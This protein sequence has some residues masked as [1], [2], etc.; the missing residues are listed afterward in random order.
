MTDESMSCE[1]SSSYRPAMPAHFFKT[2]ASML[3]FPS[4]PSRLSAHKKEETLLHREAGSLLWCSE[5]L[6][7]LFRVL[8]LEP[9]D[10]SFG[11]DD[12]LCS[13]K[14]RMAIRTNVDIDIAD[15]GARL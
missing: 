15:R 9:F 11:I 10:T 12:F 2:A 13:G 5:L 6:L 1:V 14:E 7:A 8:F 4:S 3:S